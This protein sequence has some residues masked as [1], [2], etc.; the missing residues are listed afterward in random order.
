MGEV[1]QWPVRLEGGPESVGSAGPQQESGLRRRA[2]VETSCDSAPPRFPP[3]AVSPP[4]AL[5]AAWFW[6]PGCGGQGPAQLPPKDA[7]LW[8]SGAALVG[9]GPLWR[10]RP[11]CVP[12]G[13][14][15]AWGAFPEPLLCPFPG[16]ASAPSLGPG[17]F[18]LP[19]LSASLGLASHHREKPLPLNLRNASSAGPGISIRFPQPLLS[20]RGALESMFPTP[21]EACPR[22]PSPTV[23]SVSIAEG[24]AFLFVLSLQILNFLKRKKTGNDLSGI[25]GKQFG[26]VMESA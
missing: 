5:P 12:Q 14:G 1:K 20:L 3:K 6:P 26:A 10:L 17:P 7:S 23:C 16:S 4:P 18:Y 19:R 2:S 24:S 22:G 11:G 15:R 13:L 8:A 21:E 25:F 9:A